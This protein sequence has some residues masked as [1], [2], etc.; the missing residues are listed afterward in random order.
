M[1]F[2]TEHLNGDRGS[3]DTAA[4]VRGPLRLSLVFPS[5]PRSPSVKKTLAAPMSQMQ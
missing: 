5:E 2:P 1:F 3:C 4:W